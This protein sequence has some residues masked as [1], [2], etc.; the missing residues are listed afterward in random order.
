MPWR[1]S[2][3]SANPAMIPSLHPGPASPL[4]P[5]S[6]KTFVDVD[7][8]CAVGQSEALSTAARRATTGFL[9]QV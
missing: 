5:L 9:L 1:W 3:N 7:G 4:L 2:S 8:G 6:L